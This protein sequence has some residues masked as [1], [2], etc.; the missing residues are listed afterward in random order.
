[1]L[2]HAPVQLAVAAA[3]GISLQ[4]SGHTHG[5]QFFPYTLIARRVWG[6]FVYGLNRFEDLQVYTSYGAG[7]W[8]PPMRLGTKPEIVLITF[9]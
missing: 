7:T 8:G 1:L 5:G 3:E 6:R 4:L 9:S 2:L